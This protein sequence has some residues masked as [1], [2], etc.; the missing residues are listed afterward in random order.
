MPELSTPILAGSLVLYRGKPARVTRGGERLELELEAKETV[1]VRPKDVELLHPGPLSSLAELKPQPGEMHA[2]WEILAGSETSLPE[3]CELAFGAFTPAT[4]WAGWLFVSDGLY[5]SGGPERIVAASS[6]EVEARSRARETQAAEERAW[7]DLLERARK[8]QFLPEDARYLKEIE[9][10]ACGAGLRS[11][12]LRDLGRA[13]TPENAHALLLESGV[14]NEQVDPY[15]RRLGMP[16]A[17]PRLAV[18]DLPDEPRRDLT[19]L[20]AFA[21]DDEGTSNPDDALSLDGDVL[22]IHV[23]DPAALA[24]PGSVLDLEARSRS[25]TLHLPEGAVHL[26]PD[27]MTQR[28]GLGLREVSPALSFGVRL[29][30]QG[31]IS[32]LEVVPSWVKVTCLSYAQANL[33]M[34]EAPFSRL[35]EMARLRRERRSRAGAIHIDLPEAKIHVLDGQVHIEPILSLPSRL[36]VEEAMI[37]VGEA[38]AGLAS[39][40]AIPLPY[41]TQESPD[42][43]VP[44]T[45]LA[46]MFAMRRHL[47]RSQ[48]R[49]QPAAHSGLGLPA[50]VQSTSPL[51]RYLDL[52]V[53]QQL[54]AWLAGLPLL[55]EQDLYERI[56]AVDG[57]GP[58][59]RQAETLA[60]RHWT[61]VYLLQHPGWK[62]E[63]VLVEKRGA[64]GTVLVPELALEI[65]LHLNG[66]PALDT[67]LALSV[68]GIHLP[69]L[70]VSLQTGR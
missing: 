7:R 12:L 28:L 47:R 26:F 51:R 61:L 45:T 21:I 37:L 59:L 46:G 24:P 68:A 52:V 57:A 41:S 64:S 19:G 3:L 34:A 30:D 23:A 31:E 2:A 49:T 29:G 13:E 39:A 1:R 48:Y 10:L 60:E 22:W 69:S 16:A 40:R 62:G 11:R 66:D 63:G 15:P 43:V 53:H 33:R 44:Y 36:V 50:Y 25:S 38:V 58:D 6:Q 70:D 56:G 5:F 55:S 27:E 14:W 17:S 42:M 35:E 32:S 65:R 8:G 20:A 18:P 4:A 67:H 9:P 54:R